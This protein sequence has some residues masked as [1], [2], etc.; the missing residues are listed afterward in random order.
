M[1]IQPKDKFW[2]KMELM[3]LSQAIGWNER[4]ARNVHHGYTK[5]V[6]SCVAHKQDRLAGATE[7]NELARA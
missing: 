3:L 4:I 5:G 1:N 6:H 2:F 7:Y